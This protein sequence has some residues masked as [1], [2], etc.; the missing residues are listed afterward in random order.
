MLFAIS[1]LVSILIMP[2]FGECDDIEVSIQG[3]EIIQKINIISDS[4]TNGIQNKT[5]DE[6]NPA[7]QAF[8]DL[9]EQ[10]IDHEQSIFKHE[11]DKSDSLD[12][13][14][15]LNTKIIEQLKSQYQVSPA[16]EIT[17]LL[18]T[19]KAGMQSILAFIQKPVLVVFIGPKC[20]SWPNCKAGQR[21]MTAVEDVGYKYTAKVRITIIDVKKEKQLA[22]HHKIMLV[23]TLVFFNR[24]GEENYRRSG[25]ITESPLTDQL[26]ELINN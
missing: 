21:I 4:I 3:S 17:G 22:Q 25:E 5:A 16:D 26:I 6:N 11:F 7:I 13:L 2:R 23:P 8:V 10:Y 15:A 1:A 14:I 19:V 18:Q 20:S 9:W 24:N 12:K